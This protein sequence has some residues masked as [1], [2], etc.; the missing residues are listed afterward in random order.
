MNGSSLCDF[1]ADLDAGLVQR[2]R[3]GQFGRLGDLVGG[4]GE[5]DACCSFEAGSFDVGEP[6]TRSFRMVGWRLGCERVWSGPT[7]PPW[8]RIAVLR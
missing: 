4:V 7:C 6:S 2:Q 1:A 8:A 3:V 5:G